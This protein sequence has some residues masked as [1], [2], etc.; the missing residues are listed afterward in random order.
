MVNYDGL[1][2][3]EYYGDKLN[4]NRFSDKKLHF[5]IIENGTILPYKPLTVNGV[6]T[7]GLG[8]VV[9]YNGNY[10]ESSFVRA[11][12]GAAYTPAEK[13]SY[14]PATVIY[15]GMFDNCWGHCITDD[16][17]FIWF[18]K[19][20]SFQKYFQNCP[21]VFNPM[22]GEGLIPNFIS[23]LKILEVD[24]EKLIPILKPVQFKQIILPDESVSFIEGN[25]TVTSEYSETINRIRH[26]A[27]KNFSPLPQ[28][29]F[30]FFHGRKS[31]GEEKFARYFQ[32]QDFTVIQPEK[33]SLTEQLNILANC[34]NFASTAGS[35]AHNMIF[36]KDHSKVT[37]IP[38]A[39]YLTACHP[40]LDHLHDLEISYVD[41]TVSTLANDNKGPF[42]YI[43]S[44]NLRK[45]F[46]DKVTEKYT[47]ED[48]VTFLVYL[49]Y[50]K[51]RGLKENPYELA[52]LKN[53]LPEFMAQLMTRK[54]LLKKFGITIQ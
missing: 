25:R 29:K 7:W 48:F 12:G 40:A 16:L 38:R 41:S 17:K 50:A 37:I 1:Y 42:C 6:W 13:V 20:A 2:N 21:I 52:Y 27:I 51:S 19:S 44:E 5:R 49:R 22:S 14:S 8:G 46:G 53:I 47:D 23:L 43:V 31:I 28:K 54:D 10:F 35:T 15:L 45:H 4:E 34:E 36:L 9:D 39:A 26:F 24:T 18:L 33:F 11:E 30:Y 3:K 32:S